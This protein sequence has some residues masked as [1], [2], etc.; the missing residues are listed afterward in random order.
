MPS[1][2]VIDERFDELVRELQNLPTAP[3]PVRDRVRR[4]AE[5]PQPVP[6][7]WW[8][9]LTVRNTGM[10]LAL[11]AASVVA[12]AIGY[13]LVT[14]GPNGRGSEEAAVTGASQGGVD[15]AAPEAAA[16]VPRRLG[17]T[18]PPP[19]PPSAASGGSP[20]A[21]ESAQAAPPTVRA[22][23]AAPQSADRDAVTLPPG[24]RLARHKATMRLHVS[25]LDELSGATQRAMQI[26]RA[27]GGFVA[28]VHYATPQGDEGDATLVLRVPTSKIQ[29]AILRL[30]DLG[31]IVSQQISITDLQD[32]VNDQTDEIARLR[33]TIGQLER[34]LEGQ[35]SEEERYRLELQLENA[36]QSLR[37]LTQQ[38]ATTV[39]G[40][41]LATINLAL[42]T[43]EK[44]E[45]PAAPG[46]IERAVDNA[47]FL[48]SNIAAGAIWFLIV[49]GPLLV[50]GGAALAGNRV[51]RRRYDQRLLEQT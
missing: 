26:A 44:Q 19:P 10:S 14:S 11:A 39:R 22:A 5:R 2:D 33:R 18:P 36:R 7:K 38:R 51:R 1:P 27:L 37:S 13:G 41:R 16:T 31:T 29:T 15:Q 3:E 9:W 42:T 20:G 4:I 6:R 45:Q 21:L 47:V 12:V 24:K 30:S 8:A 46:R 48:L 23:G 40:A 43:R 49:A 25:D 35:V 32:R 17:P 34:R 28:S 50:L